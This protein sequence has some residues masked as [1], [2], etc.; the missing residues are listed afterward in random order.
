[1][2]AAGNSS[3]LGREAAVG[4]SFWVQLAIAGVVGILALVKASASQAG[5]TATIAFLVFL[6]AIAYG[7]FL[8]KHA[9]D[10]IDRERH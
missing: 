3:R 6:A 5:T 4:F 7:L 2:L 8:I 1:M 10:R 9:F